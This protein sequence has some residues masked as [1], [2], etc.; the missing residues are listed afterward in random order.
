M[1]KL[2]YRDSNVG[3]P[4]T[5]LPTMS[6]RINQRILICE[7]AVSQD[8][9]EV[10]LMFRNQLP[11]NRG[12][13]FRTFGRFRPQFHM[14]NVLINLEALF[15]GNNMEIVDIVPMLKLDASSLY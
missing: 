14:K 4:V 3:R 9:R 1:I 12:M 6:I 7:Y 10:G 13:V 8:D 11:Q 15:V 2:S 5:G